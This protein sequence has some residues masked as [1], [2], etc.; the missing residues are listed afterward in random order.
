MVYLEQVIR[1]EEQRHTAAQLAEKLHQDRQI[2]LSPSHL[3][4]V[5]KKRG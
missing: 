1:A 2:R 4:Q 5:L 3:R